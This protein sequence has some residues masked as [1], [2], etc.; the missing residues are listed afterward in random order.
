MRGDQKS[1][2]FSRGFDFGPGA[3]RAIGRPSLRSRSRTMRVVA[4]DNAGEA[5]HARS[6]DP[7]TFATNLR[8][9]APRDNVSALGILSPDLSEDGHLR[10]LSCCAFRLWPAQS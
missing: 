7:T 6:Y 8:R 9:P 1:E 3:R 4:H 2:G 5:G 10:P